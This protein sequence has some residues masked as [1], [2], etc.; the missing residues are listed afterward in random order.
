[1]VEHIRS[2]FP[3]WVWPF[4]G[5]SLPGFSIHRARFQSPQHLRGDFLRLLWSLLTP[6]QSPC[7]LPHKALSK[8]RPHVGQASPDKNVN[9]PCAT[10][11]FTVSHVPWALTC[12]AVLPRDSALYDV[13][14]RQ[15]TSLHSRFLQ[16]LPHGNA[17]AFG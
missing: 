6:A 8:Q 11:P 3:L 7:V 17:L 9:F 13:S 2:C 15:L 10:A 5:V 1:M 4:S 16:T 12:C 14:V